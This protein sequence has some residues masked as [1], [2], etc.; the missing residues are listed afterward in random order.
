MEDIDDL[1]QSPIGYEDEEAMSEGSRNSSSEEV[2]TALFSKKCLTPKP[3]RDPSCKKWRSSA[4]PSNSREYYT[5]STLINNKL[6]KK[7]F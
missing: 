7:I 5:T 6:L 2:S 4:S 1:D 3:S